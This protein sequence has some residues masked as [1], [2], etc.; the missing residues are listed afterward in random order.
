MGVD[1][2]AKSTDEATSNVKV[3]LEAKFG[4]GAASMN[5]GGAVTHPP[6]TTTTDNSPITKGNP[7]EVPGPTLSCTSDDSIQDNPV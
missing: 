3:D 1:P 6:T 2:G 4:E 7:P 5:T